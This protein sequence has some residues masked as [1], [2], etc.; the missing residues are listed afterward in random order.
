MNRKGIKNYCARADTMQGNAQKIQ[1]ALSRIGAK[2]VS[3]EYAN[4][5]Q[6]SGIG[7]VIKTL[8]GE[9]PVQLPARVDKVAQVMY[10]SS[11]ADLSETKKLQSYVTAWANIR[12]WVDAQ[13][14][15][16]ETEMVKTEEVFL[17]YFTDGAGKTFFENIEN[18]GFQL[19]AGKL[20]EG[21]IL[22]K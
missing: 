22:S 20:E 7:F 17:P 1:Y 2:T 18:Q 13:C 9:F 11:L 15:L 5:G 4:N 12:D 14:A 16:I 10:G 8:Q 6:M 3:F 21:E 19:E